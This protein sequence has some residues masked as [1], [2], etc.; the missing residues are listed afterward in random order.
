MVLFVVFAVVA[1]SV[2]GA[3][4]CGGSC[5]SCVGR[6]GGGSIC[7]NSVCTVAPFWLKPTFGA[8]PAHARVS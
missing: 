3:S 7:H 1:A 4:R 6:S 8:Q 2:V 5:A